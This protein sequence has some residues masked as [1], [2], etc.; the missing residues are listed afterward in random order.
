[1]NGRAYST[2][3]PA[4]KHLYKHVLPVRYIVEDNPIRFKFDDRIEYTVSCYSLTKEGQPESYETQMTTY[5]IVHNPTVAPYKILRAHW[6]ENGFYDMAFRSVV[7]GVFQRKFYKI[8]SDVMS[9]SLGR[10]F[11][12]DPIDQTWKFKKLNRVTRDST[13]TIKGLQLKSYYWPGI[14][15]FPEGTQLSILDTPSIEIHH[16]D[17]NTFEFDPKALAPVPA[18]LHHDFIHYT[19]HRIRYKHWLDG[20]FKG[21]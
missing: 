9:D 2:F 11:V 5:Q 1:M 16:T 12:Y 4:P 14:A 18:S 20:G 15:G 7:N 8:R 10:I 6:K 13:T 19:S 3:R 17:E 21:W